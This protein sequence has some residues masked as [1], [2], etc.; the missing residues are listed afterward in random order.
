MSNTVHTCR[1]QMCTLNAAL[2]RN[3]ELRVAGPE[4]RRRLAQAKVELAVSRINA[5]ERRGGL[6]TL[7]EA[8]A[9]DPS[10]LIQVMRLGG[11]RL[12]RLVAS[13]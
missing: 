8:I 9:A 7:L 5:G 3:P 1:Q 6:S 13:A 11:R 4:I 10:Q 2:E 12:Q